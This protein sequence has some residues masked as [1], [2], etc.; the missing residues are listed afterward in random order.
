MRMKSI[1]LGSWTDI[2]EDEYLSTFVM[3]GG[4]SIKFAASPDELRPTLLEESVR[5]AED[6]GYLCIKLDASKVR[7]HMAHLLFFEMARQID[8]W[9][10]ARNAVLR[11]AVDEEF[12]VDGIGDDPDVDVFE[13]IGKENG[14]DGA[15]V[16]RNLRPSISAK[17]S[18]NLDLL[19]AFRLAMEGLCL[20][21]K[22]EDA[23]PLTRWLGG[24]RVSIVRD[25]SIFTRIDRTTAL[26]FIKSTFNWIRFAGY[27][28]TVLLLDNSRVTVLRNPRD[29]NVYYTKGMLIDHYNLL[30]EF[31]DDIDQVMSTL[32]LVATSEEFLD[33]RTTRGRRGIGVYAALRHRLEV[34][35]SKREFV[36]PVCSLVQ[37]K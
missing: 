35:S 24:E 6:H 16:R 22:R 18:N 34:D 13:E 17:V 25:F 1:S 2:L 32:I 33:V 14:V 29:G 9:S 21:G 28:G 20:K 7:V 31:I 36:N 23:H 4:S 30:R 37:L 11:L 12:T 26:Y 8:W 5:R 15:T 10:L 3:D 19:R 27:S